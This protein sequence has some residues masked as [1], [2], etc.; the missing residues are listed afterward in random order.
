MPYFDIWFRPW[1][2]Y[3][4]D[5][6]QAAI[7]TEGE[8]DIRT[9]PAT[10]IWIATDVDGGPILDGK[11]DVGEAIA[12]LA[13]GRRVFAVPAPLKQA[14]GLQLALQDGRQTRIR[15]A[16][17]P[18]APIAD[19]DPEKGDPST[20]DQLMTR[21][22]QIWVRL[23]EV[24]EAIADPASLWSRLRE[25]W[26]DSTT[27][28][29][30][31]MEIIVKQARLLRSVIDQLDHSPRRILRRVHK[32]IPLSTVQEIDRRTMTWLVRQPGETIAERSGNR[33]RIQA[34]AREE[35]FNT[36]ENRVVMSYAKLA[37]EVARDYAPSNLK[38]TLRRRELVVRA[39]G[40][41]CKQVA[42]D[43]RQ[44]GVLEARADATPNFVLQNNPN[45]HSI[46]QAWRELLERR[47][48]LDELWRWQARSWEE[49]CAL[50][51]VVA[52][53]SI[54]GAHV[55]ATSP[56]VF[57]Q[58]QIRGRWVESINP[59]GVVH[60]AAQRVVVEV[61]YSWRND[62]LANFGAA[63]WLRAGRT[64]RRRVDALPLSRLALLGR[65]RRN[66]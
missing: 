23:R 64:R 49:F 33:Q 59:F 21:I 52:L 17:V 36:L 38:R 54:E 30:P 10:T 7:L 65:A 51:L 35:E 16:N 1:A 5:N 4:A 53:Q 32:Q 41:R 63:I 13:D 42:T 44:L 20:G 57:R 34:V 9:V 56:I 46:W 61:Q 62:R 18:D 28:D 12:K 2:F 47:R 43:F 3:S 58:E 24:E 48:V 66:R 45:Y 29:D 11:P 27:G 25:L 14:K 22:K 40:K 50:A 55:I 19:Y 26:A 39:F 37:N 8:A 15:F 60:L 31:K 6:S